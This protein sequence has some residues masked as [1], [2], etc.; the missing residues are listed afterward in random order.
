[1][2]MPTSASTVPTM[3]PPTAH[4]PHAN[5]NGIWERSEE[6]RG[7]HTG[8]TQSFI[9]RSRLQCIPGSPPTTPHFLH[10]SPSLHMLTY[11][12]PGLSQG[13]WSSTCHKSGRAPARTRTPRSAMLKNEHRASHLSTCSSRSLLPWLF[14][15]L[16]VSQ[17]SSSEL[18]PIGLCAFGGAERGRLLWL[19]ML[20]R[21]SLLGLFSH[22][23]SERRK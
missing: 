1:M 15:E 6:G 7:M 13:T 2:A 14:L 4:L 20:L 3:L 9:P 19:C 11:P 23:S 21:L 18:R 8:L 17:R 22:S 16:R 5:P 12:L 10:H